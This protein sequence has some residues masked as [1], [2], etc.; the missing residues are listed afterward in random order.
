[1][2][3]EHAAAIS[4][5]AK[6][7]L[8]TLVFQ[9]DPFSARGSLPICAD[10]SGRHKDIMYSSRTRQNTDQFR[11]IHTLRH[12]LAKALAKVPRDRR[13]PDEE[14]LLQELSDMAAVNIV[15]LIYQQKK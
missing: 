11:R 13:T 12:H 15:H 1:M 6:D 14:Q 3:L 7:N 2:R 10:V 8:S 9:V 5:R 4:A